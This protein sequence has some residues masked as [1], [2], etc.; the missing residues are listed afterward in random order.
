MRSALRIA[1]TFLISALC[2]CS[3]QGPPSVVVDVVGAEASPF[4]SGVR[5]PPASQLVR[6]STAEGLVALDEQG[7]VIP[8]LADRWIVTE[9]GL[10]YIFRLR[11][12][13]WP[14]GTPITGE[15]VRADLQQA[16]RAVGT[17]PLGQEFSGIEEVRAMAGRVVEIRLVRPQPD[18]LQLLAQPELGIIH[19]GSGGGPMALERKGPLALLTPIPPARLGLPQDDKWG[20]NAR[21]VRLH[22]VPADVATRRFADGEADLVLGG[23]FES[24]PLAA[25]V[26]GLS[27][28]ALKFDPVSGLFGLVALNRSGVLAEPA[29]REGLAMAI[30]RDALDASLDIGGFLPTTRI[31]AAG[32]SEDIGTVGERWG[33]VPIE[34]RREEAAGRVARWKAGGGSMVPLRLALPDGPGA[35]RLFA[36]LAADLGAI[37]VPLRRVGP[38][39]E[40]DLQLIDLVARYARSSWYLAQLSC[41][42]RRGLCSTAADARLAEA[43]ATADPRRRAALLAEAEAELTQANVFIPLG[44]PVRWSLARDGIGGFAPNSAGFHPL[45][46]LATA[47]Q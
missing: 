26:A 24:A 9:D 47:R 45:Y 43:R 38:S 21:V 35:D 39:A 1:C 3:R 10:S 29:L 42:A 11:D 46:P 28:R 2:A 23:R 15:S 14:D 13:L 40:A 6:S 20:E 8:A 44:M 30:D 18:L 16:L 22:A 17:T 5:L 34:R 36:R 12:G 37:G 27:R 33:E 32:T 31:V 7:R 4:E 25:G 19:K 41:A